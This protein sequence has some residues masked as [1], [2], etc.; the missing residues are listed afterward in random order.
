MNEQV[1]V[2]I[3]AVV[4]FLVG[5][6]VYKKRANKVVEKERFIEKAEKKGNY[7][8]AVAVKKTF[9]YGDRSSNNIELRAHSMAVSYEFRIH[10]EVFYKTLMF[11][12]P[13]KALIKYPETLMIYYDPRDP[14]KSIC[15]EELG[16]TRDPAKR[17]GP[18]LGI[19]VLVLAGTYYLLLFLFG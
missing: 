18:A 11:Q 9:H 7:T 3:S 14:N 13:G 8:Q 12:N 5:R 2:W 10:G 1:L 19:G 16:Y 15:R 6:F 17:V 4:A